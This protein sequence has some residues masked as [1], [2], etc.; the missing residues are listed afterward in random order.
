[1][2]ALAIESNVI[3][4]TT[5]IDAIDPTPYATSAVRSVFGHK[6][7]YYPPEGSPIVAN[8]AGCREDRFILVISPAHNKPGL[9]W[10]GEDYEVVQ[11]CGLWSH[12]FGIGDYWDNA[13][14]LVSGDA[15]DAMRRLAI[16]KQHADHVGRMAAED[17]RQAEA[18][19]S[20]AKGE[21]MWQALG[22]GKAKAYLVAEYR[23]DRSDI[24]TDYFA[25]STTK[26]IVLAPSAHT[27]QLFPEMRKAC[28]SWPEVAHMATKGKERREN[29]SMGRGTYLGGAYT[30]QTGWNIR[31]VLAYPGE[32]EAL[33]RDLARHGGPL[34]VAAPAPAPVADG[35]PVVESTP[36]PTTV[37]ESPA[38]VQTPQAIAAGMAVVWTKGK[39]LGKR[40]TV[41][42]VRPDGRLVI[43]LDGKRVGDTHGITPDNVS[44]V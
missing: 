27:R 38:P 12:K 24:M 36:S 4:F 1:M 23:E 8:R 35:G 10:N 13:R 34:V 2:Q 32:V 39:H 40:G 41:V 44:A 9:A 42:T 7:L 31:K 26:R 29:Y 16:E 6:S 21:A 20:L 28:E 11:F 15:L 18:A 17:A 5:I 19:A 30:H 25:S 22:L 33:K 14:P 43:D 37:A 3:P